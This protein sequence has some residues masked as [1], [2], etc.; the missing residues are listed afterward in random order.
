[1]PGY[2]E[3]A[4][5]RFGVTSP[6]P[7]HAP[8]PYTPPVY[9]KSAQ[10]TTPDLTA[11]ATPTQIKWLQEVVGVFLYH[12]RALDLMTLC[13]INKIASAQSSATQHTVDLATHFLQ[14]MAT[15]PDTT[16]TYWA[17]DMILTVDVDASYLSEF[18]GRSR[19]GGLAY[20]GSATGNHLN[21]PVHHTSVILPTVVTSAA[22]AEY[23]GAF[24]LLRDASPL[25]QTAT[26]MG[27][28]QGATPVTCDNTTAVALANN[29]CKQKRSRAIDMRYHWVRDRVKLGDF[30]LIWRS[31][32][33][34]LADY[35]TKCHAAR[36]CLHIHASVLLQA[37]PGAP[38]PPPPPSP[39]PSS[40]YRHR[41]QPTINGRQGRRQKK[42]LINLATPVLYLI[43]A[44]AHVHVYLE[45]E[46]FY[47]PYTLIYIIYYAFCLV[48]LRGC[49]GVSSI[50]QHIKPKSTWTVIGCGR[51]K[52]LIIN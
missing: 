5:K 47:M 16:L 48:V 46:I 6:K 27:H 26:D 38:P 12:A 13:A 15:W 36:H 34:S 3:R 50:N 23:A 45:L 30:K 49:V 41:H 32:Q 8:L 1:M 20:F 35:L 52:F 37:H 44:Y 33:F 31:N 19:A 25:R 28:P 39:A 43:T 24:V 7:T 51:S 10:L 42:K 2:V 11:P 18:E 22:E 14:H 21:G 29:T 17:S 4:L 9:G 40:S